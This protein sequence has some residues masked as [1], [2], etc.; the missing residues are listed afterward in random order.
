[1]KKNKS[2]GNVK[3]FALAVTFGSCVS[4][5]DTAQAALTFQFNYTTPGI[6]F[7]DASLGAARQQALMD[8]SSLLGSYFTA[9][10]A[11]LTFD[12]AS[13]DNAAST[14]LASAGSD[15]AITGSSG[16][17]NTTVQNKIIN[18]V[19]SNG[20]SADGVINWNFGIPGGWDLDDSVSPTAYD[21]K[22]TAMHELLHAFGLG[23]SMGENGEG[24][25]GV[26]PGDPDIY[27]IYDQFVADQS[28][29]RLVNTNAELDTSRTGAITGG[30]GAAGLQ[31]IGPNAVAANGGPVYLY[32]PNPYEDGSS[33]AHLDDAVYSGTYM[34]E[35]ATTT[36]PG[37]RT[38]SNLELG[39]LRDIGYTQVTA[40]PLPAA[41]WMMGGGLVA[42]FS[43]RRN[44]SGEGGAC[45]AQAA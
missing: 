40:V 32:S 1:M 35:A 39:M 33:I 18:G 5:V 14:T 24:L 21:F 4:S 8:A 26:S 45:R 25:G 31:F 3:A 27:S 30:T 19:D 13:E 28:G 42:F 7:S 22:S 12:V 2:F 10:T 34:M 15:L 43:L 44:R 37:V 29:A 23:G 16:F 6:G 20:A 11:T 38:I 41:I 36:G 17:F 9:Y